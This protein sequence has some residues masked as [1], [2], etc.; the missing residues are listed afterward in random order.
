MKH[1]L[2][3]VGHERKIFFYSIFV[4]GIYILAYILSG[5]A[6]HSLSDTASDSYAPLAVSLYEHGTF[7]LSTSSPYLLEAT[8]VPGY[9]FFLALFAAPWGSVVPA[10]LLQ[11]LLFAICGV[12]LYR[13]FENVFSDRVRFFGALLFV[14][15]P[16]TA[17]TVAQ[18]LSEAL[19]L[20]LF[21]SG[22]Y[23]GRRA[24]ER[25]AAWLFFLA[26][27]LF[28]T[29]IMTRPILLYL[30]PCVV[31]IVVFFVYR[32]SPKRALHVLLASIFG[33]FI[34]LTPWAYRNHEAF[35]VWALSTKGAYTLYF[36]DVALLLQYR[37]G[38]SASEANAQLFSRAQIE[39]PEVHTTDDL[40]SPQY[41]AYM[42]KESIGII[43]TAPAQ[44]V[45]LY[46]ASLVTFFLSDGYRLLWYEFSGGAISLPNITKAVVTG[47][48]DV[49][50]AYV[51]EHFVQAILLLSG[52][53]FWS[54]ICVLSCVTVASTWM[55]R[56]RVR[57]VVFACVLAVVYFAVITGPVAQARYRIVA[58]PFLFML[59]VAGASIL[60][61]RIVR[62]IQSHEL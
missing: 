43:R 39:Y 3:R 6:S 4:T 27:V 44:F 23:V 55:Q 10:L 29:A 61:E 32:E 20:F 34:M 35:G 30:L 19:F 24:L 47:H 40:R 8:H 41:A 50:V 17:F 38:I 58:T 15:E 18:P 26:T 37:D 33:V 14:I 22:L 21:I 49:L 53:M 62:Y 7:T 42:T 59:A 1:I 46:A 45:K 48:V 13:L 5:K 54:S 11:A 52:F 56:S 60:R 25:N 57:F 51:R 28:S 36:Y 12:L 9:P 2:F 16:Y 31:L